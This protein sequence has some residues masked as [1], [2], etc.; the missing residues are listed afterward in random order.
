[1]QHKRLERAASHSEVYEPIPGKLPSVTEGASVADGLS[2]ATV[3]SYSKTLPSCALTQSTA[4]FAVPANPSSLSSNCSETTVGPPESTPAILRRCTPVSVVNG[5]EEG[6]ESI[7]RLHP[8]GC[9]CTNV[10]Y[11]T[12]GHGYQLVTLDSDSEQLMFG[13][14]FVRVVPPY[15][16][17]H[18][19]SFELNGWPATVM[20]SRLYAR[21]PASVSHSFKVCLTQHGGKF[22]SD[23]TDIQ[24]RFGKSKAVERV[25]TEVGQRYASRGNP[26]SFSAE[27][28]QLMLLLAFMHTEGD[29]QSRE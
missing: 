3:S 24:D 14:W 8:V 25:S 5:G 29:K 12:A 13:A 27:R 26:I 11:F 9:P 20:R 21:L 23:V 18:I 6:E 22:A 17:G 2:C 19:P 28:F 10:D 15:G 16:K 7:I 4:N 1:M